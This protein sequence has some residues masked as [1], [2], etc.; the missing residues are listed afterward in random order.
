MN[1]VHFTIIESICGRCRTSYSS[2]DGRGISGTSHGYCE[3]DKA[4]VREHIEKIK[5]LKRRS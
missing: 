5:S 4:I 3:K 1:P 2:K